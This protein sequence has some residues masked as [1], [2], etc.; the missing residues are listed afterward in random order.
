MGES[1]KI[2]FASIA[3]LQYITDGRKRYEAVYMGSA[4]PAEIYKAGTA[5]LVQLPEKITKEIARRFAEIHLQDAYTQELY[6]MES[7]PCTI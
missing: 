2:E 3:G 7:K 1:M 4:T 6:L 5:D